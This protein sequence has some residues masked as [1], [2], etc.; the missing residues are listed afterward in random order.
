MK[1]PYRK[2]RTDRILGATAIREEAM[3]DMACAPFDRAVRDM[4][5][6]W[7]IDRLPEL[8]PPD[9][10]AKYGAAV[11][12]LNLALDAN[13]S[14]DVAAHAQNC[15]RGL[16]A[17]D[18]RATADRAAPADPAIWEVECGRHKVGIMRD[19]A[20]WP[21]AAAQRPDLRLVSLR[22]VANALEAYLDH[23]LTTEVLK[24]FPGAAVTNLKPKPTALERE[25]EDEIPF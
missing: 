5:G 21:T 18:A 20:A 1:K 22:V 11:H 2:N 24:Q 13:A 15:I 4:D 6:K 9:M 8:V 10:A 3:S 14:S 7:G 16:A 12:A 23:N 25:L 19:D 17:M